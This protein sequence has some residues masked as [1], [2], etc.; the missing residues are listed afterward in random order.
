MKNT[1]PVHPGSTI[2]DVALQAQVSITTVSRYLN[3]PAKVNAETA[4]RIQAAMDALAY[5]PHGNTGPKVRRQVGRIGVLTPFFPAPSFVQRLQ[6]MIPVFRQAQCEVLIYTVDSPEQLKEYLQSIVFARR[7]DG[8]VV[9]SMRLGDDDV[10]KLAQSGLE[11][12][13]VEQHHALFSG[14]EADNVEGGA[15]AARHFVDKGYDPCGFI[16]E[17]VVLPYSLHPSQMRWQGY[18][19]ALADAGQPVDPAHVRLGEG[20]VAD[21]RRM[22]LDLLAGLDR[23]R[24]VFAQSDL[25]A[26]GVVKAAQQLGLKVPGEVAI[27]GFDDIEAAEYMDLSTVSQSL[28]ESG[29]VA[30]EL[31][32][33]RIRTPGQPVRNLHLKVS[34]V[35][36]TTT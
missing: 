5:I 26:I 3:N 8:L 16:G 29:K 6:G 31:L 23:P 25:Q 13:L 20:T 32:L 35:P 22:A 15:L 7:L 28:S 1:I 19:Q 2:Y 12:V 36:R 9:L 4:K 18:S 33:E 17:S 10:N 21:A 14:V 27:L 11:V 30:A 34:V 24:A